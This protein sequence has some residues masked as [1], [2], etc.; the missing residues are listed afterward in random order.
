MTD[1]PPHPPKPRLT[2]RVGVTGHRPNKLTKADSPRIERQLRDT[3]ATIEAVVARIYDDNKAVYAGG[4]VDGAPSSAKPYRIRMI[5][6]F[7]EGADQLATA[8][9]PADWIVEAI[10]PFPKDEYLKDFA[11]SAAGD[12]RDVRDEFRSS[13]ARASVVTELPMPR[14]G[15]REQ[16]YVLCGSFL[17]RQIDLLI[18]VWDGEEPKPGGTGAIAQEALDGGIPVVW[19]ATG[20]DHPIA[21]IELD[22]EWQAGAG[23][24]P[25]ERADAASPA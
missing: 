10:L 6:G 17:L 16:G 7:A 3:L 9:C 21:L 22:Q 20:G 19:L 15:P 12:G 5:S 4:P 23:C 1:H 14:S 24:R 8:I 13:L 2:L 11:Q 25:L 18:A